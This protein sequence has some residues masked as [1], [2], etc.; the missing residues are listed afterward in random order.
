[1]LEPL[2]EELQHV[3]VENLE[4]KNLNAIF[5][6]LTIIFGIFGLSQKKRKENINSKSSGRG[7]CKGFCKRKTK[8]AK[9][10]PQTSI[11][12]DYYKNLIP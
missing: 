6:F 1:M 10:F 4:I 8:R 9:N 12:R 3:A 5:I 2:L 7:P 11:L